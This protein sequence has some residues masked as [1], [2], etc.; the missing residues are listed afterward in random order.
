[1]AGV[2]QIHEA[3]AP[4]IDIRVLYRIL[5]LRQEVF[6]VEQDCPFV[7]LDGRDLEAT[8]VHLWV[9][10]DPEGPAVTACLRILA[11]PDGATELGRIVTA[12]P[13]RGRGLGAELIE[14]ALSL[15]GPPWVL[16]AQARLAGWYGIFGFRTSGPDFVED[17]IAHVPMR[18]G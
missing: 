15:T 6:V 8:T 10:E 12:P 13:A 11:N 1:V 9:D 2:T 17:G 7:D 14:R 4:E 16:K 3:G 5:R 18:R